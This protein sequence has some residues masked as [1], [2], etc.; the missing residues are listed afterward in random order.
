MQTFGTIVNRVANTIKSQNKDQ[1]VPKRYILSI[2]QSKLEF[3][4]AQ[5]LHDKS[6]FRED[7]LYTTIDCVELEHIDT[8][9]C[10]IVEFKSCNT[11]MKG[12]KKLPKIVKY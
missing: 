11:V 8:F 1:R 3:L 2:F 10:D 4:I 7:G 6:L 12:V 5:K 9:E